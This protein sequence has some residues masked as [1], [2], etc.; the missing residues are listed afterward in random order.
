MSWLRRY[1]FPV[2]CGC[3]GL[4]VVTCWERGHNKA[5]DSCREHF[6]ST[7][8]DRNKPCNAKQLV[9]GLRGD[10]GSPLDKAKELK[11]AGKETKIGE[12]VE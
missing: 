8:K 2:I 4:L 10:N 6:W 11:D 7:G 5:C 3:C 12:T 9:A 1:N